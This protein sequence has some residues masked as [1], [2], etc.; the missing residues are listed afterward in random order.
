MCAYRPTPTPHSHH[1]ASTAARR[2]APVSRVLTRRG[3]P[4]VYG[5]SATIPPTYTPIQKRTLRSGRPRTLTTGSSY[6]QAGSTDPDHPRKPAPTTHQNG[7]SRD[8]GRGD[9]PHTSP[10]ST[11]SL[12]LT[13]R[14]HL[15]SEHTSPLPPTGGK[16]GTTQRHFCL[17]AALTHCSD[18]TLP[19]ANQNGWTTTGCRDQRDSP[20][21]QELRPSVR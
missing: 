12:V 21:A 17:G 3:E 9:P 4:V 7:A 13:N 19:V 20:S 18:D 14:S 16:G 6:P 15:L 1:F 5:Q 2:E 10:V 11:K 8:L